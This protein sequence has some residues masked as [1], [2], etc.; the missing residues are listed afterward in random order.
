[1]FFGTGFSNVTDY[2]SKCYTGSCSRNI[3]IIPEPKVAGSP[4]PYE[5]QSSATFNTANCNI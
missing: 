1:M 3:K 4:K 5:N 2:G